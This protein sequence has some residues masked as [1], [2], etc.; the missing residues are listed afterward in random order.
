MEKPQSLVRAEKEIAL[1]FAMERLYC[2]SYEELRKCFK[3]GLEL[4]DEL[5][6]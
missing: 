1:K 4:L 6:L 3:E 5:G 2:E